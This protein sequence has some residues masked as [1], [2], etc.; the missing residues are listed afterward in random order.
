MYEVPQACP[1]ALHRNL[2]ADHRLSLLN[3]FPDADYF[4]LGAKISIPYLFNRLPRRQTDQVRE[5]LFR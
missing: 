4:F 5:R 1:A 3:D 2:L